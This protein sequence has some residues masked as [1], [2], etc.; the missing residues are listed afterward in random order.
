MTGSAKEHWQQL[1]LSERLVKSRLW[2]MVLANVYQVK[3][4]KMVNRLS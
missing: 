3:D 4:S 2:A 1:M